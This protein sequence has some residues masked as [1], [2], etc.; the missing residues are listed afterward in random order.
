MEKKTDLLSLMPSELESLVILAGQP[1]FRAKQLL[2]WLYKDVDRF[3]EMTDLPKS[4]IEWLDENC[5]I[6]RLSVERKLVSKLDGTVKYL[7]RLVDNEYVECVFMRYEHG[8]TVCIST[9]VGCRM[10]CRFCASTI[11]GKVRDLAPSE[12]IGQV[13]AIERDMGERISNI[14]LMGMG[15]PLDNYDNVLKFLRLI[16]LKQ[17]RNIGMRHISLSTC[18]LVDKIYDLLNEDLQI[19]LSISLHAPNDAIRSKMMPISKKW[20]MDELLKA[21]RAYAEKTGRRIHF[22][23]TVVKGVND[24]EENARELAGKLRG[25]LCHVNLIPVNRVRERDFSAPDKKSVQIFCKLLNNLGICAT[26]RRTLGED[27]DAS[28]GQLRHCGAIFSRL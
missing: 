23:Y 28:C 19:N 7:L 9:Q 25:M 2:S 10:G 21:C 11:G 13:L 8:N 12:M 22:E 26:I 6:N 24:S 14:V 15:E 27:V 16:N 3:E 5:F 1:K 4:F 17:G 20:S 18:G